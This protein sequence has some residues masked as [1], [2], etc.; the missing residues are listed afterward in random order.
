[1]VV[2]CSACGRKYRL[3]D[4]LFADGKPRKVRCK[5]CNELFLVQPG[6]PEAVATAVPS[7]PPPPASL[8]GGSPTV[9]SDDLFGG[10]A[11]EG[12]TK[13]AAQQ[14]QASPF[15]D[16][17]GEGS[18]W[19]AIN[20]PEQSGIA[21]T[22]AGDDSNWGNISLGS[23]R[24]EALEAPPRDLPSPP[25]AYSP[26]APAP[27][28]FSLK[29]VEPIPPPPPAA[30]VA[31][32]PLAAGPGPY[33]GAAKNEGY[34]RSGGEGPLITAVIPEKKQTTPFI[35]ALVLAVGVVVA[36]V[37][38]FSIVRGKIGGA[39]VAVRME[40]VDKRG[41][42]LTVSPQS[43]YYLISGRVRNTGDGKASFTR[44]KGTIIGSGGKKIDSM[45]VACGHLLVEDD[46]RTLT[47]EQ[48][49]A[50]LQDEFGQDLS[51]MDVPPGNEVPFMVAFF[52]PPAVESFDLEVVPLVRQ[53]DR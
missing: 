48:V 53:D 50:R 15:G 47:V 34:R 10:I 31:P 42:E 20:L 21:S 49:K 22:P 27:A 16:A 44:V 12:P 30:A 26:E 43:R 35:G 36:A 46:F 45:T 39:G 25:S 18:Q 32:P 29:E 52:N 23:G 4:E 41:Y 14:E 9:A 33:Q 40:V 3:Q 37:I 7:P 6:V 5:A 38:G 19:G 1:M 17:P 2:G 13:E 8:P 28:P 11:W 51:N 24:G